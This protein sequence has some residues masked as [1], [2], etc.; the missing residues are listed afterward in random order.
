MTFDT[1][2]ENKINNINEDRFFEV[3]K[4]M[5]LYGHEECS[6]NFVG[7]KEFEKLSIE[8]IKNPMKYRYSFNL[9]PL[10]TRYMKDKANKILLEQIGNIDRRIPYMEENND[11]WYY[12]FTA[13]FGQYDENVNEFI[14]YINKFAKSKDITKIPI[15][16]TANSDLEQ[17]GMCYAFL[18]NNLSFPSYFQLI[19]FYLFYLSCHFLTF[20]L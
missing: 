7:T 3:E 6:K 5:A 11:A 1:F 18:L 8:L 4:L 17:N 20:L 15:T 10:T 13:Q 14:R 16:W 19:L 2:K 9:E 12:D